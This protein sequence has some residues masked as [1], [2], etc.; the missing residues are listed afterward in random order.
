MSCTAKI[1]GTTVASS[2]SWSAL[3][4]SVNG[5]YCFQFSAGN[6]DYTSFYTF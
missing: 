5:G 3:P 1:N 6:P 4:A 2:G